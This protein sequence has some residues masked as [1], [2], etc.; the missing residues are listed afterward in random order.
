MARD[1][2]GILVSRRYRRRVLEPRVPVRAV[3]ELL[4]ELRQP[5]WMERVAHHGKLVRLRHPDRLLRET[6]RRTVRDP[7]WV[8][9]HRADLD[10]LARG[11]VAV[12]VIDHLLAVQV[13]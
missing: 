3:V 4:R 7:R 10:V 11:E 1:A 12:D 8:E 2:R 13:R 5:Q 9:R 6:R